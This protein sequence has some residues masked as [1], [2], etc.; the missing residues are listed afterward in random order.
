MPALCLREAKLPISASTAQPWVDRGLKWQA[1][2]V[3]DGRMDIYYES[4]SWMW[5]ISLIVVSVTIHAIG[6]VMMALVGVRIKA[7]VE[8]RKH[9]VPIMIG[10]IAV[11]GVLLTVLLG[12][13]AAIWAAAY[14]WLGTFH[15]SFD[16][17]LFSVG[18]MTTVGA[19]GL[20]LQRHWQMMGALE[21]ASGA[22]LFGISTAYIFGVMQVYWPLLRPRA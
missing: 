13:E 1:R 20:A 8:T 12:M 16:A 17:M 5:G 21:A 7:R 15:S 6:V 9:V 14:L 18:S 2:S 22:L 11:A 10:V 4:A 3:K 19:P